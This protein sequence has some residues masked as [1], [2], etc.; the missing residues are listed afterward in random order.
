MADRFFATNDDFLK[1][2]GTPV[3]ARPTMVITGGSRGLGRH[4]VTHFAASYN[5]VFGWRNSGAE[6]ESLFAAVQ[7]RGNWVLPV[8]FDVTDPDQVDAMATRVSGAVAECNALVH[9]TGHFSM[10]PLDDMD[11]ETWRL[12]MDSTVNAG[13]Y[14]WRSFA[15][16]LR[17]HE[18]SRV[19]FVGDSAAEHLRAKPESTSYYIGKHGLVLLARTIARENQ[20]SGLTCNVVS[21]GVLPNSVD[22]DQPGMKVNISY[23]EVAGVVEYLLSPGA[24]AVSG[25]NIVASRGWNV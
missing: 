2:A 13:F 5:V 1:R 11:P 3:V 8:Q 6:A 21:P 24:D 18:R 15:G 17:T 20:T 7:A 4:L 23:E 22:L 25:S 16:Q 14:A 12:E 9:T 19:V 10:K